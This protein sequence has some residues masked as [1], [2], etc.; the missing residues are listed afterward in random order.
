MN[1]VEAV[2]GEGGFAFDILGVRV[3]SVV[4]SPFIHAGTVDDTV[5]DHA[6]IPRTVHDALGIDER[7]TARDATAE[8]VLHLLTRGEPRDPPAIPPTPVPERALVGPEVA[9]DGR[10]EVELDDFQQSLVELVDLLDAQHAPRLIAPMTPEA[11]PPFRSESDVAQ[12]VRRFQ[13][14]HL[15][16]RAE[17]LSTRER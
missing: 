5:R 9:V 7:L 2:L 14:N 3:P 1:P 17:R 8:S 4:V 15:G 10:G 16:S 12:L 11:H 13:A 6:T